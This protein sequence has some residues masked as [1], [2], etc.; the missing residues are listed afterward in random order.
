MKKFHVTVFVETDVEAETKAEAE[1]QGLE[2][3]EESLETFAGCVFDKLLPPS[4]FADC[5][6][7][8]AEE[9]SDEDED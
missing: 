8:E 2:W 4:A 6:N 3:A 5:F 1:A 7:A 9:I